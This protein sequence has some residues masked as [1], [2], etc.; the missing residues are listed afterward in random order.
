MSASARRI[1]D[2]LLEEYGRTYAAEAGA[3]CPKLRSRSTSSGC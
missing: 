3:G 2:A 1:T